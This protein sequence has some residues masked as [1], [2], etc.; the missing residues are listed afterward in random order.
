M[1]PRKGATFFVDPPYTA[2]GKRAGTRLY[3][4]YELDHEKLF[5]VISKVL[6]DFLMTYDNASDVQDLAKQFN[7]DTQL[8]AMKGTHHREMKELLIGPDLDWAR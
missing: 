6:G 2:G 4:H 3:R 5:R 1:P 7:L 8:V